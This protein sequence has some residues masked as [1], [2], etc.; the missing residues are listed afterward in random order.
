[1]LFH[2]TLRKELARSFGATLVVLVTIV[3]TMTLIRTL[4]QASRGPAGPASTS[5]RPCQ[6]TAA[7]ASGFA[8]CAASQAG[9]LRRSPARSSGLP[10]KAVWARPSMPA[11]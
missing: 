3:M 5:G 6:N 7:S 4:S 1:M 10:E 11:P 9:S 2:S 8:S